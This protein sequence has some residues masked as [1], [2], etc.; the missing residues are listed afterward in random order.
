[1]QALLV[2]ADIGGYTEFM[3][4]HRMSIAHAQQNTDRLLR[5]V[6]E[7]APKLRLVGLEGDA[8]FFWVPEPEN[9][10][11]ASTIAGLAARMHQAFHDR[12][13][14]IEAVS[15][16]RCDAC[17]QIGR[18]RVKFVAHIGEVVR[19]KGRRATNIAGLDVIYVHRMLKNGVPVPEY[20]LFSEPVLGRCD[21]AV[22][23][24]AVDIDE[25]LEGVGVERLHYLD[26]ELAA[27]EATPVPAATRADKL[28]H[29]ATMTAKSLPV[30]L[31][32]RR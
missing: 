22:Q 2:I 17:D 29:A 11:V 13:R 15:V 30:L 4:L 7:A 25:E 1:M 5:A 23:E 31:G 28:R 10:E 26:L 19:Q 20:L 8:A 9:A 32:L 6:I 27:L 3:R 18:L 16:C 12:K 21:R 14:Q 24:Q